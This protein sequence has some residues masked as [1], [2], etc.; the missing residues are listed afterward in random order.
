MHSSI[1][2]SEDEADNTQT[3]RIENY[4]IQDKRGFWK[5]MIFTLSVTFPVLGLGALGYSNFNQLTD[6]LLYIKFGGK[7][8]NTSDVNVTCTMS[9]NKTGED[10]AQISTSEFRLYCRLGKCISSFI[11]LPFW[12]AQTDKYGRHIAVIVGSVSALMYCV[13]LLLVALSDAVPLWILII[14]DTLHGAF[15]SGLNLLS[16]ACASFTADVFPQGDR[17]LMMVCVDMV[18]LL[19]FTV[20][21]VGGGYWMQ[22]SG[23]VPIVICM[24]GLQLI[25]LLYGI[26]LFKKLTAFYDHRI[27]NKQENISSALQ[28]FIITFKS[29]SKRRLGYARS[30]LLLTIA[31]VMCV[32]FPYFGV[33]SVFNIY[34]IGPP[35]CWNSVVLGIY[36]GVNSI[37]SAL[38]P[39]ILALIF[40][41]LQIKN[42]AWL[43]MLAA[44][45]QFLY[46]II[47]GCFSQTWIM[48]VALILGFLTILISSGAKTIIAD[49]VDAD[50]QGKTSHLIADYFCTLYIVKHKLSTRLTV[51]DIICSSF[52]FVSG[53]S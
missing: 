25:V 2:H 43:V 26:L 33:T 35:L 51:L 40:V 9:L 34:A 24:I 50:E 3:E 23:F 46:L 32:H 1:Q 31:M 42:T 20:G 27:T 5:K 21:Q 4:S 18:T 13:P 41:K 49:L 36:N 14:G 52:L 16:I 47:S 22:A 7:L 19:L 39:I 37:G 48:F 15:G 17:V 11:F 8:G 10:H 53:L 12:G 29:F 28:Y 38:F 44:L 45:S 6:Q 30:Y